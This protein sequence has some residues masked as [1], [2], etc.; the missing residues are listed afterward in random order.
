VTIKPNI[1]DM[2]RKTNVVK[3]ILKRSGAVAFFLA[4]FAAIWFLSA[5]RFN[6][7]WIWV[8][9]AINLLGAAIVGPIT[10]RKTPDTVAERGELKLIEKWDTVITI[11]CLITWYIALP[12]VAGLNVRFGWENDLSMAWHVVAAIVYA[13][14]LGLYAWSMVEN[15]YFACT[16]R[17]QSDRGQSV[18]STGPYRFVRHPGYAGIIIQ[19][20][21]APILLG[22]LWAL[23]SGITGAILIIVRTLL[24]DRTLQTELP[25]YRDYIK[26][27]HYRLVPGIW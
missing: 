3:G 12:L 15:A 4:L 26:K 7:I 8:Y 9:M 17:I 19:A 13:A 10:I 1:P 14:G 18:C 23:I 16:V 5:G 25:G 21:S 2:P 22:S 24:E 20:I 11:S 27:V 6:W